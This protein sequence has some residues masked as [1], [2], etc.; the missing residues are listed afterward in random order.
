MFGE[1]KV[2]PL[3]HQ[4]LGHTVLSL[5]NSSRA[6]LILSYIYLYV[7]ISKL[8]S[9]VI[10][11]NLQS[12]LLLAPCRGRWRHLLAVLWGFLERLCRKK[13][14]KKKAWKRI[15][16]TLMY[17]GFVWSCTFKNGHSSQATVLAWDIKYLWTRTCRRSTTKPKD[18]WMLNKESDLSILNISIDCHIISPGKFTPSASLQYLNMYDSS[19]KYSGFIKY[20]SLCTTQYLN[21]K[22]KSLVDTLHQTQLKNNKFERQFNPSSLK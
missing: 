8:L 3:K 6:I 12:L 5:N 15:L 10:Q 2:T 17:F 19:F 9:V 20:T 14:H 1:L 18:H 4:D 21:R 13:I 11:Y 16:H 22:N 7:S